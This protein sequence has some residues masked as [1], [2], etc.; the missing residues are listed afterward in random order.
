MID[1][2]QKPHRR[3]PTQPN[4][5]PM[6]DVFAIITLF[7]ITGTV[8]GNSAIQILPLIK[9]PFSFVSQPVDTAPQI[10]LTKTHVHAVFLSR[11]YPLKVFR[12]DVG[13]DPERIELKREI[14]KYVL[15]LKVEN[16]EKQV[17]TLI[18]NLVADQKVPYRDLYDVIRVF[19]NEGFEKIALIAQMGEG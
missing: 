7:L 4:L 19:R 16:S 6:L 18:L 12:Q 15:R 17:R 14:V 11:P 5:T 10:S 13:L 2:F 8:F 9:L 3:E 1:S